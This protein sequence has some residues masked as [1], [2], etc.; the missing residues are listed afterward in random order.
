MMRQGRTLEYST[1]GDV[2]VVHVEETP[3]L[4]N[5][6]TRVDFRVKY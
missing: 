6:E 4:R 3:Q 5:D 1:N 2:I